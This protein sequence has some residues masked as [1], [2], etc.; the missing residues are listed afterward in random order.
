MT[1]AT[2]TAKHCPE[3]GSKLQRLSGKDGHQVVRCMS[4]D[5]GS[6]SGHLETRALMMDV[7][8]ACNGCEHVEGGR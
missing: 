2:A 5:K 6:M 4:F 8:Y 1:N 7:I 3:C